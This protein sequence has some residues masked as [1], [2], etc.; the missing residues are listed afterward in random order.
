MFFVI[1]LYLQINIKHNEVDTINA[2]IDRYGDTCVTTFGIYFI[3][4]VGQ[5]IFSW[6]TTTG[7]KRII[8]Y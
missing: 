3:I 5:I 6:R 8:L 7:I 4:L 1:S 2:I